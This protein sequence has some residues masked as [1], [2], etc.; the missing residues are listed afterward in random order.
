MKRLGS[1]LL[2]V[3]G[4]CLIAGLYVISARTQSAGKEVRRLERTL[5]QERAAIAV[6]NAEI[7]HLE[8]PHRLADL[9]ETYLELRP[10][11]PDQILTLDDVVVRVARRAPAQNNDEEAAQ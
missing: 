2:V 5:A 8:S 10:T 9:S 3:L 11:D 1:F 6:L 7:A 4:F